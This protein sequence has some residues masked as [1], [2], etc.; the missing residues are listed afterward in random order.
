MQKL[1]PCALL[2]VGKNGVT[3]VENSIRVS[4]KK[5]GIPHLGIHAKESKSGSQRDICTPM[6]IAAVFTITNR[7]KQHKCPS[8]DG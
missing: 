1:E 2:V 3:A 4:S 5:Y 6:S 7:W 8:T